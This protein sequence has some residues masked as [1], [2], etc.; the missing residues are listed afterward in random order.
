[1]SA[2]VRKP[3]LQSMKFIRRTTSILKRSGVSDFRPVPAIQRTWRR[4]SSRSTIPGSW[5]ISMKSRDPCR[6][7]SKKKPEPE[8]NLTVKKSDIPSGPGKLKGLWLEQTGKMPGK[9]ILSVPGLP[10]SP[11]LPGRPLHQPALHSIA[12]SRDTG[13]GVPG[14]SR[15]QRS[16]RPGR[17]YPFYSICR[18]YCRKNSPQSRTVQE[19]PTQ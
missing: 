4:C 1:L 16:M 8:K 14:S 9:D 7:R 12:L 6:H 3:G 11:L 15:M 5:L 19:R 13:P 17:E 10:D 2:G 18:D